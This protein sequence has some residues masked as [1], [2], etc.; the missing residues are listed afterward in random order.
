MSAGRRAPPYPWGMSTAVVWFRRDLRVRD[1]P[2]LAVACREH[3]RVVPLFVFDPRLLGGRF[4]SA[5]RTQWLIDAL[6]VLD[7]ALRER[8]APLVVRHG[9][10]AQEVVAVAR[11]AGASVVHCSDDVTAFAR[12]RDDVVERALA[13]EGIA[14][15][16]GLRARSS[17]DAIIP[18]RMG[19]PTATLVSID[20]F[21]ALSNYHLPSD[22]PENADFG[23]AASAARLA[24]AVVRSLV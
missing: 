5:N 6:E 19:F 18:S 7:G 10:V 14:L 21:K 3:E 4:R 1:L 17:T 8:G 15:R 22:T 24:E 12:R 23:T 2:A 16:R 9:D 11:E 20:E 13:A